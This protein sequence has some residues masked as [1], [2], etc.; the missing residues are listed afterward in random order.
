ML[1]NYDNKFV[2]LSWK[3]A[4]FCFVIDQM[5]EFSSCQRINSEMSMLVDDNT[6]VGED[7]DDDKDGDHQTEKQQHS[8]VVHHSHHDH[9]H[10]GRT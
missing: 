2:V 8:K 1:Q 6:D 7:D 9:Y 10:N 4:L 3:T 5:I